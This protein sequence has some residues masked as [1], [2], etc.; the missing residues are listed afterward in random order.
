MSDDRLHQVP[1]GR[2][3]VGDVRVG[4]ENPIAVALVQRADGQE[5]SARVTDLHRIPGVTLYA[6][7][8][9]AETRTDGEVV[10]TSIVWRKVSWK[11]FCSWIQ[12]KSVKRSTRGDDARILHFT[13]G[14]RA[15]IKSNYQGDY[16]DVTPG[17]GVQPPT[18]RVAEAD[19]FRNPKGL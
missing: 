5:L 3:F 9:D 8:E 7:R 19:P 2:W 4:R 18:V 14:A 15:E 10:P 13:D 17:E 6:T 1:D 16:S 11:T 12:G